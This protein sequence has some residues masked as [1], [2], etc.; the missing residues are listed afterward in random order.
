MQGDLGLYTT[1]AARGFRSLYSSC[2]SL[3][4]PIK[5]RTKEIIICP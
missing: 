4:L 3:S 5:L 2:T 1:A